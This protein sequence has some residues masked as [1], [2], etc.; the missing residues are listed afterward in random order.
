MN[1]D[2]VYEFTSK[3]I[4]ELVSGGHRQCN[5]FLIWESDDVPSYCCMGVA[6]CV[7]E[8]LEVRLVGDSGGG[9][10]LGPEGDVSTSYPPP[11]SKT[12]EVMKALGIVSSTL[13]EMNDDDSN[14]RSFQFI[15]G[16]L[17]SKLET[18]WSNLVTE[19]LANANNDTETN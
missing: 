7:V 18:Y 12:A 14:S 11:S 5:S 4:E 8:G 1:E 15:A 2:E 3:W 13:A 6:T 17:E 16:Y 10:V 9:R 19:R